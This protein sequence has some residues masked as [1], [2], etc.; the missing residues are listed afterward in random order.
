VRDPDEAK[1]PEKGQLHGYGSNPDVRELTDE[2]RKGKH[3]YIRLYHQQ[4][5]LSQSRT[6]SRIEVG[7]PLK[8]Q[9]TETFGAI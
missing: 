3:D 2:E 9:L 4:S 5:S 6:Q 8:N 7:K 1:D